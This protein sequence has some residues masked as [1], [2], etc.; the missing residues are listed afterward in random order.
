MI[1]SENYNYMWIDYLN[2]L[3]RLKNAHHNCLSAAVGLRTLLGMTL[4]TGVD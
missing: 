4:G 1:Y 3:S 2:I